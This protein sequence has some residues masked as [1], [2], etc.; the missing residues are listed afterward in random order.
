[1]IYQSHS[2][3]KKRK[4]TFGLLALVGF[5]ELVIAK[6]RCYIVGDIQEFEE[7]CLETHMIVVSLNSE[8]D[9]LSLNEVREQKMFHGVQIVLA[10]VEAKDR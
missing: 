4:E 3:K 10:G 8:L 5:Q 9:G 1:M 7:V 6:S 2:K